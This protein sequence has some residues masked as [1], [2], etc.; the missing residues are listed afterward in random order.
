MKQY[1]LSVMPNEVLNFFQPQKGGFFVD[2]TLGGGGHTR[3]L[4]EKTQISKL[5]VKG[6]SASGGKS[7][8]CNVIGID[9]DIE[10][11]K[12]SQK[13]LA[14]FGKRIIF[15][16]DNFSNIKQILSKLKIKQISGALL[17]L[18]VSTHQLDTASRGFSFNVLA[19]LD[20]R[21]DQ[22]QTLTLTAELIVNEWPE[23]K[24]RDI[25]SKLGES[26][27]A[28]RI[29]K[30]IIITRKTQK[31]TF[32][33]QLVEI[34]QT[35]TP[36]KWR[37]SRE[38]H[39]ATNIFR[40]LRMAANSELE[41]LEKAIFE[42]ADVLM[43]GARLIIISFHSL[44]DRLVKKTFRQLANP[45]ECPPKAPVCVCGKKPKIKILTSKPL[46]P[47]PAEIEQNP[48]SRSAKMRVCEKN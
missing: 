46:V 14:K 39:F 40:A 42:F 17:D 27:F 25:F 21:L 34:I 37:Y 28:G 16:Q 15:V 35:A 1:H 13:K 8:N 11:I 12:A 9:L 38:K 30:Q 45:C 5:S 26:P 2:G 32:T 48:K 33:N 47:A 6:G 31:I 44:E 36:P 20:M 23:S 4:L 10:A 7:Q 19:K 29:A 3:A 24:L 22:S 18:G 41:N 43:P